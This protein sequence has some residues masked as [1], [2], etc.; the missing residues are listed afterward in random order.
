M[1]KLLLIILSV[2]FLTSAVYADAALN[3]DK[4]SELLTVDV[5]GTPYE[6]ASLVVLKPGKTIAGAALNDV[7]YANDITFDASGK[8]VFTLNFGG[9]ASGK[10]TL[11]TTTEG[12]T[13]E[14]SFLYVSGGDSDK[15]LKKVKGFTSGAELFEYMKTEEFTATVPLSYSPMPSDITAACGIVLNEKDSFNSVS[16]LIDTFYRAY[17]V[18]RVNEAEPSDIKEIIDE[19]SSILGIDKTSYLYKLYDENENIRT[20]VDK[21]LSEASVKSTNQLIDGLYGNTVTSCVANMTSWIEFDGLMQGA[22]TY[23]KDVDYT[24]Y[25]SNKDAIAKENA[26]KTFSEVSGFVSAVNGY[27]KPDSSGTKPSGGGSGGGGSSSGSGG[28]GVRV[29]VSDAVDNTT[30]VADTVTYADENEI[31]DYAKE[32]VRLLTNKGILSGDENGNFNPGSCI[33]REEFAKIIALLSG[34]KADFDFT[35]FKDVKDDSW[36]VPYVKTAAA[37]KL[38]NGIAPDCFGIGVNITRQDMA[39]IITRAADSLGITLGGGKNANLADFEDV[40]DYAKE[41]VSRLAAAGIMVGDE[42]GRFMPSAPA[43]RAQAAK[44]ISLIW[45]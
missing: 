8:A 38:M 20:A 15:V 22:K 26:G 39:V 16:G 23:L 11:Y 28:G 2:V 7:F 43:T 3:F 5:S 37:K 6:Q 41:A 13:S 18:Q 40:S 27:K 1:K 10:Y 29:P 12:K 32:G 9:S 25:E 14:T 17:T 4:T 44:I 36:Y 21:K 19:R 24:K 34:E 35:V 33:T 42:N 45:R 30:P 31:P